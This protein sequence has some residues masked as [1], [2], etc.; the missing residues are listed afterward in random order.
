MMLTACGTTTKKIDKSIIPKEIV[1]TTH[2][3]EVMETYIPDFY[4][5]FTD[6]QQQIIT[7]KTND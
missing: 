3:R 5:R 7:A 4:V 6:Q 1:P 2:E